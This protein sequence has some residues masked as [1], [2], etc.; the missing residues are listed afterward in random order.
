[1]ENM[2]L[3]VKEADFLSADKFERPMPAEYERPPKKQ[4]S[5]INKT[6]EYHGSKFTTSAT[7]NSS[8]EYKE[9]VEW[10]NTAGNP[11]DRHKYFCDDNNAN[12]V[13]LLLASSYP[14]IYEQSRDV[15]EV[16]ILAF[17]NYRRHHACN[18]CTVYTLLQSCSLCL[19]L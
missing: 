1:M 14:K 18:S 13:V 10:M 6:I 2:N 5:S 9:V 4:K 7:L 19:Y 11:H 16:K 3:T 8:L 17:N 15:V 12:E